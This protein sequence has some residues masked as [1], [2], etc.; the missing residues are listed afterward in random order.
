MTNTD[1]TTDTNYINETDNSLPALDDDGHL[2][3]HTIWS[4]TIAQQL[5]DTLELTLT[6][7]HFQILEKVQLFYERYEHAPATRPLIK[8]LQNELPDLGITNQSLQADFNT[9]LVARHLSRLAGLPKPAN[10]L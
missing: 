5:A 8:H 3:D 10:C 6:E 9:G 2:I 4:V 7:R 1:S